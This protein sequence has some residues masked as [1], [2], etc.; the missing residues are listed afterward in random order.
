VRR[1]L[2]G[3][4]RPEELPIRELEHRGAEEE[5]SQPDAQARPKSVIRH[6]SSSMSSSIAS[7]RPSKGI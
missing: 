7:R 3:D 2:L 4:E 1:E 5:T 6:D